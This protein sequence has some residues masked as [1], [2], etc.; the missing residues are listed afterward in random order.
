MMPNSKV[1]PEI[2]A[3]KDMIKQTLEC[4]KIELYCDIHG[5]STM[6]NLFVYANNEWQTAMSTGQPSGKKLDKIINNHKEKIFPL[7]LSKLCDS[8]SLTDSCYLI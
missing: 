8:F 6:K 4:R 2:W 3:V 5:H 1:T 7:L